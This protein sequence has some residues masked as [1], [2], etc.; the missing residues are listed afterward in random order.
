MDFPLVDKRVADPPTYLAITPSVTRYIGVY[1]TITSTYESP[2]AMTIAEMLHEILKTQ[3]LHQSV[4]RMLTA[5]LFAL[6][7]RVSLSKTREHVFS[8]AGVVVWTFNQPVMPIGRNILIPRVR[9]VHRRPSPGLLTVTGHFS[10]GT[11]TS[12][13]KDI[14][15][16]FLTKRGGAI[17]KALGYE[18]SSHLF[19]GIDPHHLSED[20]I[21]PVTVEDEEQSTPVL[22]SAPPLVD[23]GPTTPRIIFRNVG[24]GRATR[25]AESTE[26]EEDN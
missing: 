10:D 3:G 8:Y 12:N 15:E 18:V 11:A 13:A 14:L 22:P 4:R 19:K 26:E 6:D 23:D 24:P 1:I 5:S 7:P 25:T 21:F 17:C 16:F 9:W 20:Y 2:H